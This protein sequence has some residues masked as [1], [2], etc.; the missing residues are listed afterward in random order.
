MV[1]EANIAAANVAQL[2]SIPS[3]PSR[4]APVFTIQRKIMKNTNPSIMKTTAADTANMI[5][6]TK[7]LAFSAILFAPFF[8][9]SLTKVYITSVNPNLQT[10]ALD[11]WMS[12]FVGR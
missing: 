11:I 8:R 4:E 6:L 7:P 5:V 9:D 10:N 12:G 2:A 1:A 3:K